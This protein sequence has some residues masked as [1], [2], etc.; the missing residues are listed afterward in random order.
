MR[1]RVVSS[2]L[3][4]GVLA[5]AG[6]LA[7]P[8]VS[9]ADHGGRHLK[10]LDDC[11]PATFNAPPPA[12]VGPGTCVQH[13]R[14]HSHHT[15]LAALVSELAATQQA[16]RWRFD[17]SMLKV[18]AGRPVILENRG[19]ETHTFT[20]VKHFGGGFVPVL[21]QLSGNP[22][23]APECARPGPNGTLRPQRPS[24]VNVFVDAGKEVAFHNAGLAPGRYMFQCCFHPWMRVILTVR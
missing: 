18:R 19:G 5:L 8:A 4:A 20:M 15:T 21:N 11:D 22:D 10:I 1:K 23:P 3:G 7:V 9:Q 24:R 16:K 13:R 2:V 12:G 14:G 6:V 17:P